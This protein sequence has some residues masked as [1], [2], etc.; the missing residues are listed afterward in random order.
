M[1]R[2]TTTDLLLLLVVLL[3]GINYSAVKVALR[4]ISPLALSTSRF[5]LASGLI[6]L[7]L[8]KK[9][10]GFERGDI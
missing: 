6:F 2:F 8:I 3:W 10:P 1:K 4:E 9:D 7:I 5:I